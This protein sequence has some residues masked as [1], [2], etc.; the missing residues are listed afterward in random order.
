MQ[1]TSHACKRSVEIPA[2]CVTLADV[3]LAYVTPADQSVAV[4]RV[5][6]GQI[7]LQIAVS[8]FGAR[9]A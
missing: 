6:G 4:I 9:H 5:E 8:A 3:A 7:P 2:A 1:T